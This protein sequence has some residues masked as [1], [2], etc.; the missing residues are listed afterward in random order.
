M[1]C[2]WHFS[3][4]SW[5]NTLFVFFVTLRFKFFV[6]ILLLDFLSKYRISLKLSVIVTSVGLEQHI[7]SAIYCGDT[8][9]IDTITTLTLMYHTRVRDVMF[10]ASV[11]NRRY[12][13]PA[14]PQHTNKVD[15][16]ILKLFSLQISSWLVILSSAMAQFLRSCLTASL[17]ERKRNQFHKNIIQ[18]SLKIIRNCNI[19]MLMNK[20]QR[21][22]P[23]TNQVY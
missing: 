20:H 21:E 14:S 6:L 11:N 17:W 23:P 13:T 7:F 22:L 15:L 1:F 19:V 16:H 5:L 4:I 3:N 9:I 10:F 18:S 8:E 12:L 2:L